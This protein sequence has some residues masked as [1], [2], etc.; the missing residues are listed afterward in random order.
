MQSFPDKGVVAWAQGEANPRIS[1]LMMMPPAQVRGWQR[2]QSLN[3]AATPIAIRIDPNADKPKVVE[4]GRTSVRVTLD[5][6]YAM[7]EKDKAREEA[8]LRRRRAGGAMKYREGAGGS[9]DIEIAGAWKV[10]KGGSM[11][12]ICTIAGEGPYGPIKVSSRAY[13]TLSG[14]VENLLTSEG[15]LAYSLARLDAQTNAERS[16]KSELMMQGPPPLSALRQAAWD[17]MVADLRKAASA[18]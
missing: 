2:A 7:E 12:V 4:F 14:K 18:E 15:S 8:E 11:T 17:K 13:K 9:Y 10:G 16:L 6:P 3:V 5:G 1:L